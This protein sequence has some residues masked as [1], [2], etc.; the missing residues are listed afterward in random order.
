[1]AIV[2]KNPETPNQAISIVANNPFH[3]QVNSFEYPGGVTQ[4][5]QIDLT[6][7]QNGP[8]RLYLEHDGSLST[9]LYAD[10]YWLL[11]ETVLPEKQYNNVPT[12]MKDENDNDVNELQEASLDLNDFDITVFALPVVEPEPEV[13]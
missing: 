1:M 7:F 5:Q 13:E 6:P 2:Q 4:A 9:D 10:H 8:A 11:A 3:I 12:G